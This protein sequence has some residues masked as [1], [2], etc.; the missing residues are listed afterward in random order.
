MLATVYLFGRQWRE[1]MSVVLQ[2]A[3]NLDAVAVDRYCDTVATVSS[4]ILDE[5]SNERGTRGAHLLRCH[6]PP[7]GLLVRLAHRWTVTV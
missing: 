7:I 2:L 3:A 4:L 1:W 5:I 6:P